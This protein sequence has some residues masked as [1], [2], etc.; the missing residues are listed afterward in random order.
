VW[1]R[2]GMTVGDSVKG[3]DYRRADRTALSARKG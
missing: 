2:G 3:G 1:S